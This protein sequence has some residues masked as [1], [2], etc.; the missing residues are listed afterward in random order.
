MYET[1]FKEAYGTGWV[2]IMLVFILGFV[3]TEILCGLFCREMIGW[4][5]AVNC[6]LTVIWQ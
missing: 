2:W 1:V 5:A 3:V 4:M 6:R